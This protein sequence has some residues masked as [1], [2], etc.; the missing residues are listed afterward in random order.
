[1]SFSRRFF[2]RG[3]SSAVGLAAVAAAG[4]RFSILE[5]MASAATLAPSSGY[6]AL[7]GVFLAGGNDANNMIIPSAG[8]GSKDPSAAYYARRPAYN[9]TTANLNIGIPA[10]SLLPLNGVAYGFHPAMDKLQTLYNNHKLAVVFNVG[11]LVKPI[12]AGSIV[13]GRLPS[14]AGVTLPEQLFSH[15]DQVNAWATA[16]PD[17]L[18]L[19]SQLPAL[20]NTGWAGRL[21]DIMSPL[22]PKVTIDG[23]AKAYP[24]FTLHGGPRVLGKGQTLS[25]LTAAS[26]GTIALSSSGTTATNDARTLYL[27]EIMSLSSGVAPVDAFNGAFNNALEYADVRTTAR[28]SCL[29]GKS[30][31]GTIDL[32]GIAPNGPWPN[33]TFSKQLL[34]IAKDIL[35]GATGTAQKGLG[36]RRQI[37]CAQR[38]GFDTHSGE[39]SAHNTLYAELD[40]ALDAF[41]FVIEKLNEK[42]AAGLIPGLTPPAAGVPALQVTLFTMS[43]FGRTFDPNGSGGTDHGWG[44]HMLVLGNQVKGGATYGTFPHFTNSDVG[45]GRWLPTT[46]S[47]QYANELATWFG[48]TTAAERSTLFPRLANFPA[49][50]NLDFMP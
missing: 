7:V 23:V 35:S 16:L 46:T 15:I 4:Q 14:G 41:Y 26:D 3:A 38:G 1:M 33:N 13:P 36:Q 21:A 5:R 34:Q 37:F 48:I 28:G 25:P 47:D 6:R 39:Y 32:A 44:N 24:P 11:T 22:N 43:D 42:A 49:A 2:L 12:P 20:R 8:V 9:A 17:P 18:V 50:T 19:G 29:L 40:E 30:A 27:D 10:G 45:E 31:D